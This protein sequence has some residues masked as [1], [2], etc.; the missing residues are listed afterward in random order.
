MDQMGTGTKARL[1][2]QLFIKKS[3]AEAIKEKLEGRELDATIARDRLDLG[4]SNYSKDGHTNI[5]QHDGLFQDTGP[6]FGGSRRSGSFDPR[7]PPG[8]AAAPSFV[9]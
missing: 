5:Y 9:S 4:A 3:A 1:D 8:G 7:G 6:S 2:E